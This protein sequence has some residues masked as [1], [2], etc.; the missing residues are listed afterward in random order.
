MFSM[1]ASKRIIISTLKEDTTSTNYRVAQRW[2][3]D[4]IRGSISP[5]LED[6]CEK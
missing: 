1:N 5:S 2:E 4:C 6:F 3:K